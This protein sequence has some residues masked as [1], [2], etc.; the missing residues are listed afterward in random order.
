M[1][2]IHFLLLSCAALLVNLTAIAKP[3]KFEV[4]LGSIEQVKTTENMGDELYIGITEYYSDGNSE[5]RRIPEY[6][7]RWTSK[8]LRALKNISL[9][10]GELEDGETVELVFSLIEMDV[11]PWNIDDLIG[12]VKLKIKN[13]NGK[14]RSDWVN[15][16]R[17]VPLHSFK[18]IDKEF[19]LDGDGGLYNLAMHL[20]KKA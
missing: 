1:R 11:A 14:V 3:S 9:W 7:I 15:G 4:I 16:N 19:F 12:T 5:Y 20:V 2:L 18:K 6:P 10:S 8:S 17:I 13:E